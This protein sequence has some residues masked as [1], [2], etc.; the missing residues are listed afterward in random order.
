ML[1]PMI[2]MVLLTFIVGL[3]A[4]KVRFDSVKGGKV[5]AKYYKLMQGENVP[6]IV[7]KTTRCFNNQFE[8]IG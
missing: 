5:S 4:V 6:E 7:T 3:I 2:S 1:Y 8:I